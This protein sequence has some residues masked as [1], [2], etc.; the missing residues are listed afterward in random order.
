MLQANMSL[1]T[2]ADILST[3][4]SSIP[5]E[6]VTSSNEAVALSLKSPSK[7]ETFQPAFTY[8]FFGQDEEL[9]GYKKPTLRLEYASGSLFAHVEF[10]YEK[11]LGGVAGGMDVVG[12][13][14][15]VLSEN[16]YTHNKDEFLRRLEIDANE[17][18]PMG[19]K[20]HEYHIDQDVTDPSEKQKITYEIYSCNTNTP[21]FRDYFRRLQVFAL[22]YIEGAQLLEESDDKWEVLLLFEKNEQ[23]DATYYNAVG[24][25]TMYPFFY[26]P[27]KRRMRIS[28]FVILP[29]YQ[30]KGH[31]SRLYQIIYESLLSRSDVAQITVEDP[32]DEFQKLRD[33]CDLKYLEK[34]G[35]LDAIPVEDGE[36][37]TTDWSSHV[38]KFQRVKALIKWLKLSQRQA[39]RIYEM[40]VLYHLV[41]RSAYI[42]NSESRRRYRLMVKGRIY[43][44]N[45]EVLDGLDISE[46]FEKVHETWGNVEEEYEEIVEHLL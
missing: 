32:N 5:P 15:E 37:K 45:K 23:P 30:R 12:A 9:Y 34:K 35:G 24:F 11:R 42:K 18:K 22:W 2:D 28:Q 4:K 33:I 19:T 26:Y 29:P 14:T 1:K 21:R 16:S 8:Y 41:Q 6:F 17:F 40:A 46:R 25:V 38:V 10:K 44:H 7:Y 31:G 20:T 27:D 39:E 36:Q 13:I 3:L 43:R